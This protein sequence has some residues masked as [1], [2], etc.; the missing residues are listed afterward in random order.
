MK[1]KSS[2]YNKYNKELIINRYSKRFKQ[3]GYN[4]KTLGWDNKR[5]QNFRFKNFFEN[6]NINNPTI[7]D[8]GCGFADLYQYAIKKKI[9]I[10]SYTG[11]DINKNL[12]SV[13]KSKYPN[14]NFIEGNIITKKIS[15]NFDLVCLIGFINFKLNK[16]NNFEFA[17]KIIKKSFQITNKV[18]VVDMLSTLIDSNYTKENFVNYYNPY[19]VVRFASKLSPHFKLIHNYKSIPQREMILIIQKNAYK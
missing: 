5:N 9:K 10:K 12:I 8:V 4:P 15:K 17:K 7:L 11:I 3:F 6:I 16:L 14:C 2:N 13:A 18:L 1:N 19:D